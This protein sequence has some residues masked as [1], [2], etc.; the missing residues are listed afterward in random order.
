MK[1][2][3]FYGIRYS[4]RSS[5]MNAL[6]QAM[7]LQIVDELWEEEDSRVKKILD[8]NKQIEIIT[9]P[10][11]YREKELYKKLFE[12]ITDVFYFIPFPSNSVFGKEEL[13]RHLIF[14]P[15]MLK[16]AEENGKGSKDIPWII[17]F[18]KCDRL[19][20]NP[21]LEKLS[22]D[23]IENSIYVSAETGKG[24]DNLWKEITEINNQ[25][26]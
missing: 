14:F 8:I 24:L 13:E 15:E 17:V 9:C 4:G 21:Y 23:T 12:N 22:F 20:Y 25:H 11:P 1:K 18:S 26:I 10:S 19:S 6:A 7:N 16:K 2:V 3:L 5:T